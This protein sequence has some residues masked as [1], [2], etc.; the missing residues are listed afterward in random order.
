M[1]IFI[2]IFV[3]IIVYFSY[4]YIDMHWEFGRDLYSTGLGYYDGEDG[5]FHVNE[6]YGHLSRKQLYHL[7]KRIKWYESLHSSNYPKERL[8]KYKNQEVK[9]D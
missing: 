1:E 2:A 5:C 4:R 9:S 6:E 3:S 8:N 7:M